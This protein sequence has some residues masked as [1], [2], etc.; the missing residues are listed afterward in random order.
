MSSKP[1]GYF[2]L[3]LHSHL[4]YV[5]SHGTWPHGTD[6]LVEA[7]AETYIPLLN[8]LRRLVSEGISPQVTIGVTPVLA[9]QLADDRFR[10]EFLAYLHLKQEVARENEGEFLR[11]GD[12]QLADLAHFWWR[13]Y[14]DIERDFRERYGSDLVGA[15]RQLQEDGH[16]EVMTS[17]AT[18]GYLPLLGRDT[19][20]Q[21]QVRLGV[22]S[23]RHRFGRDPA[24][25]WLPECG[26]RPR[27]PWQRP[28]GAPGSKPELRKGVEE[29]VAEAGLRYF[30]VDSH[31]L[32]G[33]EALGVYLDRFE[34]LR[35][36]WERSAQGVVREPT[37][38]TVYRTYLAS[39]TG[40]PAKSPAVFARDTRTAIQVW[41][42]EHGYPGDYWYLEFHKKHF[43]GG[44]RYWRVTERTSDLGVKA[45][46]EP[47]R[48]PQ[49]LRDQ[50]DH[51]VDV[52]RGVVQEQ[53]R[54]QDFPVVCSPYDAELLGHW[55]FEGPEWLYQVL[56]RLARDEVVHTIT[57][58][59]YLE[60]NPPVEMVRLPEGSWGQGGFHWVWL[61]EWTEWTWRHIYE[62]E[63][64]LA[65]VLAQAPAQ[66]TGTLAAV[67][68]QL[69]RELLLLESSDWQFLITTWSARDYAENRF[70]THFEDF[71]TLAAAAEGLLAGRAM[72]P[73]ERALLEMLSRRDGLFPEV[74]LADWRAVRHPVSAE[75]FSADRDGGAGGSAP[76]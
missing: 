62:A 3:V 76:T 24:G 63:D 25:I 8:V 37:E 64:R 34:A 35:R 60:V 70:S 9:E 58:R 51:F 13:Y 69:V 57:C 10:E 56:K 26:Y 33:G 38:R 2:A 66:P 55:W 50:A 31:L 46:Y 11:R 74:D 15:L 5:L 12:H 1:L 32:A 45:P 16:I 73:G 68:D 36:L 22:A 7:A 43:P 39:S 42:G 41:S 6:W 21:A 27:Y 65:T 19:S 71:R 72:E 44:L 28:V 52:L 20:V 48:V 75:G 18:H 4:P 30:I 40:D 47:E 29:F 59:E 14:E 54:K 61:N 67:L 23:Y 53:A 17:A 49:R